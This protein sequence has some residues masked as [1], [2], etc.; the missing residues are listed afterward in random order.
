MSANAAAIDTL[1]SATNYIELLKNDESDCKEALAQGMKHSSLEIIINY[2]SRMCVFDE[3]YRYAFFTSRKTPSR[4]HSYTCSGNSQLITASISADTESQSSDE[5]PNQSP[6]ALDLQQQLKLLDDV[7]FAADTTGMGGSLFTS[8]LYL[9]NKEYLKNIDHSNND[10]A[11][12]PNVPITA[13]NL[14]TRM[15][16]WLQITTNTDTL[17]LSDTY[18]NG[19]N[20]LQQLKNDIQNSHIDKKYHTLVMRIICEVLKIQLRVYVVKSTN[21][22]EYELVHVIKPNAVEGDSLDTFHLLS[23]PPSKVNLKANNN[24]PNS[25][26]HPMSCNARSTLNTSDVIDASSSAS[27]SAVA[28]AE[29]PSIGAKKRKQEKQCKFELTV[30]E[31]EGGN[32]DRFE[33]ITS[34]LEH[35]TNCRILTNRQDF[36]VSRKWKEIAIAEIVKCV[37]SRFPSI[38]VKDIFSVLASQFNLQINQSTVYRGLQVVQNNGDPSVKYSQILPLLEAYKKN[39]P[40]SSIALE[41]NNQNKFVRCFMSF[42]N[43]DKL[44][45]LSFSLPFICLDACSITSAQK[46]ILASIVTQDAAMKKI[47]VL[48]VAILPNE[49][50]D[51]WNWMLQHFKSAAPSF[52]NEDADNGGFFGISDREKG[53]DAALLDI[54]PSIKVRKCIVHIMRNIKTIFGKNSPKIIETFRKLVHCTTIQQA[55][56]LFAQ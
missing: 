51:N 36:P 24:R 7:R 15:M 48:A 49:N 55:D 3:L 53:L 46:G 1:S 6:S 14:K 21:G 43:I 20:E 42:R 23:H 39:N 13:V 26:F 10:T 50:Y 34:N 30:L 33:I 16:Q 40:G 31:I 44:F 32:D 45:S 47:I 29:V 8:I 25:A 54:L 11:F 9:Q 22:N 2:F 27:S 19:A 37:R 18:N 28:A 41:T 35:C 4:R 17:P 5:S 38:K 52:D 12:V 56:Q